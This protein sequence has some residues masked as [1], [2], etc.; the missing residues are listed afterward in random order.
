L[1]ITQTGA[2]TTIADAT[3]LFDG[4]DVG[5]GG[6]KEHLNALT[7]YTE[8]SN[9]DSYKEEEQ[10]LA[11]GGYSSDLIDKN[12]VGKESDSLITVGK[13]IAMMDG[14]EV[15]LAIIVDQQIQVILEAAPPE[16]KSEVSKTKSD[17]NKGAETNKE[18]V[19]D[20]NK[21]IKMTDANIDELVDVLND[22]YAFDNFVPADD[23]ES[24]IRSISHSI[25]YHGKFVENSHSDYQNEPNSFNALIAAKETIPPKFTNLHSLNVSPVDTGNIGS[26]DILSPLDNDIFVRGLDKIRSELNESMNEQE[27]GNTVASEALMGITM[28]LLAGVVDWLL[29]AG[30]LFASF[31]SVA[32]L[33]KQLDV[34]PVLGASKMQ[35][36]LS[37]EQSDSDGNA[38]DTTDLDESMFNS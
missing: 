28:P 20:N 5:L 7:L 1:T 30:S 27:K 26:F 13:S 15:S 38:I 19:G 8:G 4:S 14:G 24:N 2:G 11:S 35:P 9:G 12:A 18:S 29:V 16:S 34:L 21:E 3:L 33:W 31:L 6:V 36:D 37:G 23:V 22:P 17:F 10:N 32:P 25:D